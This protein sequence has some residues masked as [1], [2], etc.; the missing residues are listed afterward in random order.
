MPHIYRI[1]K[2]LEV[3]ELIDSVDALKSFARQHGPGGYDVDEHSLDPSPE[4]KVTPRAWGKV[5][6]HEDG[7]VAMDPMPWASGR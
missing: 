1:T 6:R 2:S 5:I 7:H 4:T 3:G